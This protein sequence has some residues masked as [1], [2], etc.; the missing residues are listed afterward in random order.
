MRIGNTYFKII[1]LVL[2][3]VSFLV[4]AATTVWL[5]VHWSS[6]PDLLPTHYDFSGAVDGTGAKSNVWILVILGWFIWVTFTVL[7]FF[8]NA[9]NVRANITTEAGKAKAISLT[10]TFLGVVKLLIALMF[11]YMTVR[12]A[13]GAELSPLLIP[14]S[15]FLL[16][17]ASVVHVVLVGRLK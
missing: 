14:L 1:D 4:L 11:S 10:R 13:Q 9:W 6:L 7:D 5:L 8:P 15:I 12:Q 16:M 2:M 17:G 3:V